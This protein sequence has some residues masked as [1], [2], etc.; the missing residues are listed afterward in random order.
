[1]VLLKATQADMQYLNAGADLGW[2][3]HVS[4]PISITTV[5]GSHLSMMAEPG[6]SELIEALKQEIHLLD[7]LDGPTS[8]RT[9]RI[10][11]PL[12]P[13][14]WPAVPSAHQAPPA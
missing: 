13:A 9:S 5:S 10:T 11:D 1:V 8:P 2:S 3:E 7:L 4:G 6:V 12:P 14:G